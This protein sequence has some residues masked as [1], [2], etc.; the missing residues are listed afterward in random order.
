VAVKTYSPKDVSVIVAGTQISGFAEDSFVTV[1]RDSDAFTKIVGADGEVSR[2]ASADLSGTITLTLLGTSASNDILAALAI[3]DAISLNGEFPV[4][5]KDELGTS[6]HTAPT[7]WIQK[8]STKEYG[9]EIGDNEW[10]LQC[11][12][13][14]EFV[15][16][17]S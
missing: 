1:E 4:L 5:I 12:E 15:G 8:A 7:S 13:L 10:V 11:S 17:N 2:S 3:A 9:A 16:G 6:L 14:I